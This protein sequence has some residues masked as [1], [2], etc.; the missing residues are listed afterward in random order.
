[1]GTDVNHKAG[2]EM[3]RLPVFILLLLSML[4][5]TGCSGS[6]KAATS[7]TSTTAAKQQDPKVIE[8]RGL[9]S[10]NSSADWQAAKTKAAAYVQS[11]PNGIVPRILYAVSLGRTGSLEKALSEAQ[12]LKAAYPRDTRADATLATVLLMDR[13]YQEA[14]NRVSP[15]LAANPN[16]ER[17]HHILAVG[18][19]HL[20]NQLKSEEHFNRVR[21]INPEY[22]GVPVSFAA[23]AVAVVKYGPMVLGLLKLTF[24]LVEQIDAIN[25]TM[26]A[27]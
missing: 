14:I 5:M 8:I 6:D 13:K 22:D 12:A 23:F 25:K 7:S 19:G 17:L 26:N 2:E 10:S 15:L 18:Y 20:G 9:L 3:V 27:K 21:A 11:D 24:G 1:M 16:N 4:L